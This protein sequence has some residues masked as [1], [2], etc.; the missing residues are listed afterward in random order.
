[1]VVRPVGTIAS[2]V[3][4]EVDE[5]GSVAPVRARWKLGWWI[6]AEDRWHRAENEIAV[7][8]RLVEDTPVVETAMRV[9]GGDI[10][11]RVYGVRSGDDDAVVV[12][13]ENQ[14]AVPVALVIVLDDVR[15]LSV[16]GS[17]VQIEK[18]P[19]IWFE[20]EPVRFA[21][22]R[23]VEA[24]A[25]VVTAGDA[26][27]A[28]ESVKRGAAAFVLPLAH[29][30]TAS[31]II[32]TAAP[33]S[34][35]A[36]E[37]VVRG[38]KAQSDR[39]MR[40]VLPDDEMQSTIDAGRRTALLTQDDA[41][42]LA[43]YGYTDEAVAIAERTA[44]DVAARADRI[45]RSRKRDATALRD[46]A[47]V[48]TLAGEHQAAEVARRAAASSPAGTEGTDR[49]ELLDLRDR[50]VCETADG[51]AVYPHVP[52]EW[53]GQGIEVHDA[54]TDHGLVSWAV[55]WHGDRPALLWDA[56]VGVRVTA[57]GLDPTWSSDKGKGDAL[58]SPVAPPGTPVRLRRAT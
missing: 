5:R 54:P 51:I 42:V 19:T 34:L 1:V 53:L 48:L 44:P 13:F 9:P 50:L 24:V 47:A 52:D 14:S 15:K 11:Q 6:G 27:P 18:R 29:R 30:T 3:T 22:G 10:V 26:G 46:A 16:E 38:W 8:Q 56:P 36:V 17:V 32:G 20:K 2:G 45:A 35:P 39:G 28:L 12:S 7:R 49:A 23:T 25:D 21:W 43:R 37:Q 58:L 40:L 4:A 55:R 33:Q 31:L 57:P 41:L